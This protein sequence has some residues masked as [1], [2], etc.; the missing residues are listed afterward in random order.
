ML[1]SFEAL[2]AKDCFPLSISSPT[3]RPL[4]HHASS[5]ISFGVGDLEKPV[6]LFLYAHPLCGHSDKIEGILR[7][8]DLTS[9][10]V[11]VLVRG[12]SPLWVL[13]AYLS[14]DSRGKFHFI[15]EPNDYENSVYELHFCLLRT[16][17]TE[18]VYRDEFQE[19]TRVPLWGVMLLRTCGSWSF[20]DISDKA[21]LRQRSKLINSFVNEFWNPSIPISSIPLIALCLLFL[22]GIQTPPGD[23]P[24]QAPPSLSY[25]SNPKRNSDEKRNPKRNPGF[26]NV[27]SW[28]AKLIHERGG[29]ILSKK[30]VFILPDIYANAGGV[31]VSY[32]EW[33][34]NIQGFSW[35]K[36]KVNS[37]LQRYMKNAFQDIK[38]MCRSLDCSLRMGAFTLGV[39]RKLA[40]TCKPHPGTCSL[41][42]YTIPAPNSRLAEI[43]R[44]LQ[45]SSQNIYRRHA[46]FVLQK[47]IQ[48]PR[49]LRDGEL[50]PWLTLAGHA[51]RSANR[52]VLF[53][54]GVRQQH[55]QER[56][57]ISPKGRWS[58]TTVRRG[59]PLGAT[60]L[61]PEGRRPP[62]AGL[63]PLASSLDSGGRKISVRGVR[64][65][66][67]A[68]VTGPRF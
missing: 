8:M 31:T 15:E 67:H 4:H 48:Q 23:D 3:F 43:N 49:A 32:F 6:R 56:P 24:S 44:P 37:E 51:V 11:Q 55:S 22:S 63:L 12:D 33:V 64:A 47:Q 16:L 30:G 62:A 29:K 38:S 68:D 19:M 66:R 59:R 40:N 50:F 42:L 57:P 52:A 21:N 20:D 26:G 10:P 25:P 65:G 27:G 39:S 28:V 9:Y 13:N 45:V 34:Q 58:P 17:L 60:S 18:K 7:D 1:T 53:L 41:F 5:P 2:W 61:L 36:D 54:A 35:G 46:F 14:L